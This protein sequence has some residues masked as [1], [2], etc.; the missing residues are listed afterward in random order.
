MSQP[1]PCHVDP[2]HGASTMIVAGQRYL[3]SQCAYLW[4]LDQY[5]K[6]QPVGVARGGTRP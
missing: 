3:C 2:Q 5:Q 4:S 6:R 1:I